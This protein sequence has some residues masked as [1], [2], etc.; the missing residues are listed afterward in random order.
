[1]S[2]ES[3]CYSYRF[4]GL[5]IDYCFGVVDKRG[6]VDGIVKVVSLLFLLNTVMSYCNNIKIVFLSLIRRSFT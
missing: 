4:V 6:T 1:V 5:I 2:G 3:Y